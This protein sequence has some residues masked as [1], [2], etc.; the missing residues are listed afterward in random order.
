[1]IRVLCLFILFRKIKS[2]KKGEEKNY[3]IQK[4]KS[5]SVLPI[6]CTDLE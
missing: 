4:Q 5:S 3:D 6:S 1:M 2:K